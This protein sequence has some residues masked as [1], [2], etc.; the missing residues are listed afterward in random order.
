MT[1]TGCHSAER[2]LPHDIQAT[3][4]QGLIESAAADECLQFSPNSE[5]S[6]LDG[7]WGGTLIQVIDLAEAFDSRNTT[8]RE[9]LSQVDGGAYVALCVF[10]GS[11]W[12][13]MTPTPIGEVLAFAAGN[14]PLTDLSGGSTTVNGII[15][16]L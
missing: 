13:S 12:S 1:V 4:E 11:Q 14:V 3:A 7:A 16:Y 2:K 10:S 6:N 8:P 5:G 9:L 15:G